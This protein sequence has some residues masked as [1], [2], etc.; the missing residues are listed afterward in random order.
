MARQSLLASVSWPLAHV[1]RMLL[2]IPRIAQT[3]APS[4]R[5]RFKARRDAAEAQRSNMMANTA[6][7]R[8]VM[9]G[10]GAWALQEAAQ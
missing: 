2:R 6:G 4:G 3:I 10:Q 1:S 5:V 8:T 7:T 9:D